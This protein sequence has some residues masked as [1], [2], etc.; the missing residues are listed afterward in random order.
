M[1]SQRLLSVKVVRGSYPVLVPRLFATLAKG[2]IS[3]SRRTVQNGAAEWPACQRVIR[4]FEEAPRLSA[5]LVENRSFF[6]LVNVVA[7]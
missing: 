3:R 6:I 5:A 7:H 1:E 4:H 2:R